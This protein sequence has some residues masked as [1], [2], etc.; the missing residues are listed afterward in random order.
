MLQVTHGGAR[1]ASHQL[2]L[3]RK[4]FVASHYPR[5][6]KEGLGEVN[7]EAAPATEEEIFEVIAAFGDAAV[8]AR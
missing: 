7:R 3:R 1:A 2:S 8:R 5:H 6:P 4:P